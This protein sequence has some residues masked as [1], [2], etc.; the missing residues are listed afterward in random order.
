MPQGGGGEPTSPG[1]RTK[2]AHPAPMSPAMSR[3]RVK[4][5]AHEHSA[6]EAATSGPRAEGRSGRPGPDLD[7]QG[8]F[9]GA[10]AERSGRFTQV[11]DPRGPS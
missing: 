11:S 6:A 1:P 3:P 10:A 9:R 7:Q 8:V 4:N 5:P 2:L